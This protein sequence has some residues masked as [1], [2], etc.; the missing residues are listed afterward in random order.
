MAIHIDLNL[1]Q[2]EAF[3]SRWKIKELSIFGSAL[4]EDF[5]PESDIDVL[6]VYN[7]EAERS[8]M[9]IEEACL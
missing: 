1:E 4:R 7:E 2:I 5:G 9:Q 3:C 8:S 6:V